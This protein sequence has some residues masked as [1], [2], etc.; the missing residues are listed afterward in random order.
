VRPSLP[1]ASAL[2]FATLASASACSRNPATGRLQFSLM[3]EE[4]EIALGKEAHGEIM[5]SV[6]L[7]EEQPAVAQL[8]KRV[9]EKVTAN[10]ERPGLP[11]TF[12]VLDDPSVNAFAL[13]GGF[14]YVT[15]G[16]L[17]HL[18]SED[19]LAAVLGH[20]AGHVTARH[21]A[22]QMRKQKTAQR[23]VGFFRIIDPNLRHVGG[24][25]ASTAGLALLKYSRDD[26]TEADDLSVRYVERAGYDKAAI[27][28]VF[29]LL[30]TVDE[31]VGKVPSWLK[32]HPEPESRRQ[33]LAT[34]IGADGRDVVDEAYVNTIDGIVHGVDPRNGFMFGARFVHPRLGYQMDLPPKWTVT[35]DANG[36]V[37]VSDDENAIMVLGLTTYPTTEAGMKSFFDGQVAK[38]EVWVGKIGG[39]DVVTAAFS[40]PTESGALG[41]L[42][43]FVDYEGKI[44]ALIAASAQAAWQGK[45]DAVA[46]SFASFRKIG[47]AELAKVD[48]MRVRLATL[49]SDMTLA[50]FDRVQPSVVNVNEIAKLNHVAVDEPLKKGR[51]VKRVTGFNP[52]LLQVPTPP[53]EPA[54][55]PP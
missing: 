1:L 50:E 25:V 22:V 24:L 34:V 31:S 8:V 2:L 41:G 10:S 52:A 30:A 23:T 45:A 18:N 11:W 43:A 13:P 14:L 55:P 54:T 42:I 35:H 7:Y 3:S 48:P 19:E 36:L 16:L 26:E 28:E 44:I 5:K 33:R 51:V 21:S 37:G 32:T 47:D 29:A 38:G 20:E 12:T 9:G 4:E 15:R 6:P 17:G 46:T 53:A 27:P 40:I 39:F 49:P